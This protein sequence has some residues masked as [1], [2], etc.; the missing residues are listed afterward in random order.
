MGRSYLLQD[1]LESK[2]NLKG[3]LTC[4]EGRKCINFEGY[5]N[6]FYNLSKDQKVVERGGRRVRS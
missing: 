2:F 6:T 1:S 3:S 4:I 5:F